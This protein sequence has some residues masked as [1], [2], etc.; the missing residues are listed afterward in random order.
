M[1]LGILRNGGI[2]KAFREAYFSRDDAAHGNQWQRRAME[3]IR[4]LGPLSPVTGF[5][6][7]FEKLAWRLA[8]VN[9]VLILVF[10]FL[11]L[12]LA[13]DIDYLSLAARDLERPTLSEFFSKEE[14]G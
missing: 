3:R 14:P 5:W 6:P 8:P 4:E 11:N 13:P 12:G 2:V 7:S 10:L 9:L 1:R